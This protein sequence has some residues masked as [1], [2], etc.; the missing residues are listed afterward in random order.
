V[1]AEVVVATAVAVGVDPLALGPL[2]RAPAG[3]SVRAGESALDEADRSGAPDRLGAVHQALVGAEQRRAHGVHY[4]PPVVADAI[5]GLAF[6]TPT[7]TGST[8]GI[9]VDPACGG[10]AFLLAA[11]RLL[12][13]R[14][15]A[16]GAVLG[17]L[18]GMEIDPLAAD[19]AFAAL[20]LWAALVPAGGVEP[21][22]PAD[23]GGPH[24]R[25]ADALV[26]DHWGPPGVRPTHVV[27]NPPFGGQLARRTARPRSANAATRARMGVGSGYADTAALFLDRAA[28]E[29][30]ADGV[31]ALVQPLSMLATRDAGI[32]RDRIGVERLRRLWVPD[33]KVFS[34]SV[35]VCAPVIGPPTASPGSANGIDVVRGEGS[36][37][38]AV[39]P[40]RRLAVG[41]TWSALWAAGAG[42][43]VVDLDEA[44]TVGDWCTATA[45][46]RDEFYAL[47]AVAAEDPD[48]R[49]DQPPAPGIRR[50]LTSG[51]VDPGS[52]GWG[53]RRARLSGRDL[54]A[55][56]VAI[57]DAA[58][59]SER[60]LAA[61]VG[62]RSRPKVI[63]AT[64]TRVVEA[65]VDDDGRYWPS[66][67]LIS[68]VLDAGRDDAEHR[69]L[70]AAALMAPPV[71]AWVLARV[72][73][74]A[75]SPDAVKLSGRQVLGVPL[76]VV[77]DAWREG[78]ALLAAGSAGGAERSP[79]S[80]LRSAAPAL[81]AAYGLRGAAAGRVLDWWER[82]LGVTVHM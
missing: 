54:S 6:A 72:G 37:P 42:V 66:V 67:P 15:E 25:V 61:V 33:G 44:R 35:A 48:P 43:P 56:V 79:G 31:V 23:P 24:I 11:A 52:T 74:A 19:V 13:A 64:Q 26:V 8:A 16:P 62:A 39:V 4:T 21:A 63:V 82:R 2:G 53:R 32:V 51:L 80:S 75:R 7:D 55:P 10:G 50:V 9:V 65:V 58:A 70:V 40:R 12:H 77:E 69:W 68:V 20:R 36:R 34:A 47:A 57:A 5:V 27:G 14:G 3:S 46:F 1:L 71:T 59:S 78:A 30:G 49:P 38:V 60:R 28:Q 81:T 17:R 18:H 45:G 41:G 29:V 22:D 73:G 76:P